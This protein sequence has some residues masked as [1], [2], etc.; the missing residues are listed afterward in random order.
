MRGAP[1]PVCQP[2]SLCTTTPSCQ[3]QGSVHGEQGVG[4]GTGQP[5]VSHSPLSCW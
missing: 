5:V 4:V 1:S 2:W 3:P